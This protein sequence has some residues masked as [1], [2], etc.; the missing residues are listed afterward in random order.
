[1]DLNH[2]NLDSSS[3]APLSR[4]DYL[5]AAAIAF[6]LFL[7]LFLQLEGPG[8]TWDEAA[9]NFP[10]A[11]SQAAWLRGLFTLDRPFS[12]E[13][14]DEY[15][16]T[17]SDHPSPPRTLAALFFLLFTP[18]LDEIRSL[19]LPSA[20]EFSLLAGSMYLFLRL[21]LPA[22]SSLAAALALVAMPRVFGHAH[23]FSLDLPMI[24]AWFWTAAVGFMV[25]HG[26]CRP[27]WFG[28]AYACAFSTKL[29]AAFL[30][31]PLLVWAAWQLASETNYRHERLQRVLRAALW[32]ALLSPI[33][34]IAL[35]PWLWHDTW[36]RIA[37]RFFHY[38]E[39]AA[40]R[41]IPLYYLGVRYFNN[42]PWHYPLVMFLVT[43]PLPVLVLVGLGIGD[44][45]WLKK[46]KRSAPQ[47]DLYLFLLLHLAVPLLLV[48]L[49]MAQAYDGCRLFLPCFPFA[50]AMAGLGFH[51]LESALS[52]R[53]KWKF[54][55]AALCLLLALAPLVTYL[56]IHPF[57]LEYFNGLV[58]GIRGAHRLGFET[59][60]WCDA[61]T[62][63]FLKILDQTV[64]AGKSLKPL[65]MSYDVFEYYQ[66]R[67]WLNPGI[68][69]VGDPPW[70]FHLLQCR[71]G[72]FTQ[73]PEWYLYVR[74]KPLAVVE[75]DG[76]PLFELYGPTAYAE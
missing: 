51:R 37:D 11:K 67:G 39:K 57:Y 68:R 50:A 8:V 14:I 64:P 47:E 43:I 25:F 48:L 76:V 30:P 65:S 33:I 18:P 15:W 26:R 71:Q 53:V 46:K 69:H 19:R 54:T 70:D 75:V 58:G 21:R 7:L 24:C 1:M 72:M 66:S 62:R 38:A 56:R 10:A 44:G 49:P 4:S 13:T 74:Q 35:Q 6:L 31:L 52:V 32:A 27:V 29:H 12:R 20:L 5:V 41:P 59:T 73:Q 36:H 60:Y 40:A 42:T 55:G 34:Y 2:V 28:L 17:H 16:Y 9:P 22:A 61:L 45:I 63:D 23:L 3:A